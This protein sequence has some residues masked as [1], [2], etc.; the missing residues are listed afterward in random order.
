MQ[1]ILLFLSTIFVIIGPVA[2]IISIARGISKPHR[3]TRFILFF[4]LGLNF[5]SILAAKGNTGAIV[6]SGFSFLQATIIF[7]LSIRLGMGGSSKFDWLCLCIAVVGIIGWKITGNPAIG[8][9]F[10]IG[11]DFSA[12]LPAFLKTWKHPDTEAPL[13]YLFS[14][15][16][17]FLSLIA[18]RIELSSLFQIYILI[19]SLVMVGFIYHKK[20]LPRE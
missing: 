2:Y 20:I 10:A 6:F 18:Y 15:I 8:I 16:A 1:N 11:A 13:Y 5:L 14:A 7:L 4:V 12:Y 19:S 9:L 17:A 3:M